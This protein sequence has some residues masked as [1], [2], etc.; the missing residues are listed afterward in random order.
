[1]HCVQ[2]KPKLARNPHHKRPYTLNRCD[3]FHGWPMVY[4]F[5]NIPKHTETEKIE[6]VPDDPLHN[7]E[8]KLTF[9]LPGLVVFFFRV[10]NCFIFI[11][12]VRIQWFLSI[13]NL[14]IFEQE[15]FRASGLYF[16]NLF[17]ILPY[18]MH[19]RVH[20]RVMANRVCCVVLHYSIN[21]IKF[22]SDYFGFEWVDF[23]SKRLYS[24]N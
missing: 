8:L 22:C 15:P 20:A 2:E 7:Q 4:S 11:E 17:S 3:Q 5:I 9:W 10:H 19:A 14:P 18:R 21:K 16:M 23:T 13:S 12:C 1:M 6:P 24:R